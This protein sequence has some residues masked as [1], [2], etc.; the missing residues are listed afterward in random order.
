MFLHINSVASTYPLDSDLFTFWTTE[1]WSA[2]QK[3]DF[4]WDVVTGFTK[5][6]CSELQS[7]L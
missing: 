4:S 2:L 3:E 5:G 7:N 1:A 6:E